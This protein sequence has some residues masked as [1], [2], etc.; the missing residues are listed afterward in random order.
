MWRVVGYGA[1]VLAVLW[2]LGQVLDGLQSQYDME[3]AEERLGERLSAV[4]RVS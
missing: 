3:V 4:V 1:A 2:E